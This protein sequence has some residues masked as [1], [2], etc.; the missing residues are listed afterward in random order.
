MEC[1]GQ[2]RVRFTN[3]TSSALVTD[4]PSIYIYRSQSPSSSTAR[5]P[6]L[7]RR[8][9][10]RL[11]FPEQLPARRISKKASLQLP[12]TAYPERTAP[13]TPRE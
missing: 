13:S 2:Y 10:P 5:D 4:P 6:I 12:A 3:L 8:H 9:R 11:I 7:S 1:P